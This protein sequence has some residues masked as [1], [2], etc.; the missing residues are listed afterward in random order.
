MDQ[1]TLPTSAAHGAG[2][3][4]YVAHIAAIAIVGSLVFSNTLSN[5]YFLDDFHYVTGNVHIRQIQPVWRHFTDPTTISSLILHTHYRPLMPLSLSITHAF[6]G[7]NVLGYHLYNIFF[8]IVSAV[9]LYLVSIE[10][11]AFAGAGVQR[12]APKTANPL[13][14]NQKIAL[15]GAMIFAVHPISGFAVNYICGRDNLMMLCFLLLSLYFYIRMRRTGRHYWLW[16]PIIFF[17]VLS[18]LSKPNGI[19]FPLLVVAFETVVARTKLKTPR[20]WISIGILSSV[21]GAFLALRYALLSQLDLPVWGTRDGSGL[22]DRGV[23]LMTQLKYHLFHY[24]RNFIW[25][26]QIRALPGIEMQTTVRN[27]E[28]WIGAGFVLGSIVTAWLVRR[29]RPIVSFCIFSYWI[30]FSLTSSVLLTYQTVADRWMY[31]SLPFISLLVAH[32]IF[33][34]PGRRAALAV[35]TVVFAYLAVTCYA[36][37]THYQNQITIWSQ[38]AKYGATSMGYMNLG[39]AYVGIDDKKAEQY[40]K[41]SLE[42]HPRAFLTAINLGILYISQGKTEAGLAWV[43]KG[44]VDSPPG[45]E[46]MSNY[47]LAIALKRTGDISG[48]YN[49][50]NR[51]TRSNPYN[52]EYLYEAGFLAQQLKQHDDCIRHLGRIHSIRPVFRDSRFLMGW[53][54]QHLGDSQAAAEQY[55]LSIEHKQEVAKSYYNLGYL[56]KHTGDCDQAV[57]YFEKYLALVPDHQGAMT[58]ISDCKQGFE[59]R[60][61]IPS[62]R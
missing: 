16:G 19:L 2:Y 27:P 33:F 56:K 3:G 55:Q 13:A 12:N 38:S 26:F 52:L 61:E 54:F 34:I 50:A 23:Y 6:F 36:M 62:F 46:G 24:F 18:L 53:C 58:H 41:K 21:V 47:W 30:M 4:R 1:H 10:L 37:N 42:R 7:D 25:P 31:P 20:L 51:A 43:K 40:Y 32:L 44:V 17:L 14:A 9:F 49:A 5:D 11:L 22:W 29:R 57:V 60:E 59:K 35:G 8:H 39:H 48:A 45:T 15:L 28:V